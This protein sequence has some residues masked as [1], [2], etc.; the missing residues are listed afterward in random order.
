M[1]FIFPYR[2]KTE[3]VD[4]AAKLINANIIVDAI[5]LGDVRNNM[6]HGI[7]NATGTENSVSM[8]F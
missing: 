1:T 2:S 8:L 4:V 6:L 3:P 7:S 5:L